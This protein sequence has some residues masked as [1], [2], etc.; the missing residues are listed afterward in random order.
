[1]EH[2]IQTGL[3]VTQVGLVKTDDGIFG[4]SADGFIG[5]DGGSEYK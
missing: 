5:E 3:V 2:E 1:M 4:A